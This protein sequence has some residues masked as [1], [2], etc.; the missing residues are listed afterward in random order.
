MEI[1]A[2]SH[3]NRKDGKDE[4]LT[5]PEII[6]SLGKFDLDPC[7][8]IIRPWDTAKIH[9]SEIDDGL[10]KNWTG[11]VFCNPPY[12]TSTKWLKKCSEHK[13]AIVLIFVRTETKNWFNYIWD[14]ADAILFLKGRITF[15]HVDGSKPKNAGGAPSC[16]IAYGQNNV[17]ALQNSKIKGK[18]ILLK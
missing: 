9:Y 17:L 13:N 11:R 18:L 16:L 12:K 14:Y 2:F 6:K 7:S 1:K 4:W 15:L 10:S 5:P 8:P 3:E